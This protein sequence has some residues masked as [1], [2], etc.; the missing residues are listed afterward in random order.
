MVSKQ[1]VPT[2]TPSRGAQTTHRTYHGKSV[3]NQSPLSHHLEELKQ[4]IEPTMVNKQ[5]VP[6][7]APSRGAQ[8]T[9]R[10]NHGKSDPVDN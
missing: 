6:T 9:D 8:T 4:L 7:L 3:D 2:V 10:T 5:P 1:P